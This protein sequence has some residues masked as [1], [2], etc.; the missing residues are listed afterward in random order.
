MYRAAGKEVRS[1]KEV[2]KNWPEPI[3]PEPEV[4]GG[5]SWAGARMDE[6]FG[7]SPVAGWE[8]ER[9]GDGGRLVVQW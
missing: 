7:E 1:E 8:A 3:Q 4:E 9:D 2:K 6:L 5:G